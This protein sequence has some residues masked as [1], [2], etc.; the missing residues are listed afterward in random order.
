MSE[1][2]KSFPISLAN[3][4]SF[5][6]VSFPDRSS[7]KF[8]FINPKRLASFKTDEKETSSDENRLKT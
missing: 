3:I 6:A 5:L 4:K 2:S 8:D 1:N 7:L